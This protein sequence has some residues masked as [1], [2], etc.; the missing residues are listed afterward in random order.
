MVDKYGVG[1][2][3]YC[4]PGTSVLR[5]RLGLTSDE[6]LNE[7]ERTFSAIAASEIEFIPPP[8]DLASLKRIHRQL[9]QDIYDWAG[10][11]RTVDISKGCTHFC[12]VTRIEPE[13]E[14]I[15]SRLANANWFEGLSRHDLVAAA[16]ELF[17]DLNMTHPFRDGNGRAQRI[18]FEFIIVNAGYELSWW[19]IEE[20]EWIQANINAVVC[21]YNALIRIFDRCIGQPIS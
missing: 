9:F 11:L 19:E 5:N 12:N 16:A 8:Y 10:E 14:K 3:P 21:D 1:Q 4:Y 20:G 17:G 7:A 2:D 15:F 13:A 6:A 18:L